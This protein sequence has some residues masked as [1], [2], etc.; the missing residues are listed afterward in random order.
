MQYR[1]LGKTGINVSEISLGTW[2]LGGTWGDEFSEEVANSTLKTAI[3]HDINF[4]DTADVYRNGLS[5]KTCGQFRI[6]IDKEITIATI[7]PSSLL[8]NESNQ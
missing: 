6:L 2:Q 4:F 7:V 3:E 1:K 5:E 8:I